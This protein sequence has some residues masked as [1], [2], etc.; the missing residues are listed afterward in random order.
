MTAIRGFWQDK[1][2]GIF[3]LRRKIPEA[4]RPA[5]NC[6]EFYKVS[7]GTADQREAE[8]KF[9][10][11]NGEY[12]KK[13][14]IFR[15]ALKDQGGGALF[16]EEAQA[17]VERYLTQR[18][19][20]GFAT[21]GTQVMFILRDLD[22]AVADLSG[23][24]TPNA[25][26]MTSEEWRAYRM[27]MA[28]SDE[29]D[30]FSPE[31]LARIEADHAARH[32]PPG[33][34]WYAFQQRSPRRRRRPLLTRPVAN[35][36]R[37]IG[38]AQGNHPGMDEPLADALAAALLSP[39]VRNQLPQVQSLRRRGTQSR[40]QPDMKLSTLLDRWKD[41][42]KPTPKAL[43]AADKAI[44]DF[45]S[46]LGDIGIGEITSADC[47]D[48]R[49]AVSQMPASMSRAHRA[50]SFVDQL[51]IYGARKDLE[52]IKPPSVKK[53]L[54]AIQALLGYA[55]QEQFIPA[56]VAA[57]IKIEGYTKRSARRS[58]TRDELGQLFAAPLFTAPWAL[59]SGKASVSDTTMRWLF[60]LALFTG[61]RIEELGQIL[62]ADIRQ[63]AGI[64]FIDVDDYVDASAGDGSKRVKTD[65]SVRLLPLH[66]RLIALGFITYAERLKAAGAV[67][68]FP[69]LRADALLVQTK[70]ASR[71]A[72]RII[73]QAVSKDPRLVF[74]SFR[75]SFKDLCR[76]ADIPVDVHDQLTGHAP[77]NEGGRYGLGRAVQK[78]EQHL[79]SIR[80]D[81][82]DWPAI[83]AVCAG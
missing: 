81:M 51:A 25:Q 9:I 60:L 29:D 47:F 28:G 10:I 77:A 63:E 41:A 42:R 1:R 38:L 27:T 40:A 66:P 72:A 21:G 58:F 74:H 24:R 15:E 49:D 54:G 45:T 80:Y 65:S 20:S 31:V 56:N 44:R 11:A 33:H 30:E 5:F 32:R 22:D 39:E 46:F 12:E 34:L 26:S 61:G 82:I 48:F 73:D 3:Y 37:K 50:L 6:G 69:D 83:E 2:S 62:L 17:I 23:E 35:L 4:L 70:E 14:A 75:H 68:L 55:F 8:K 79:R 19:G 43:V 64:W 36:K 7:L 71:R 18:S 13:L 52:R 78:L 67:K 16:P 76:D 57:G 53:Y 59:A